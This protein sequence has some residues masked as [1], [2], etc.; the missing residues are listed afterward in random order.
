[1]TENVQLSTEEQMIAFFVSRC[2]GKIGR[3]Q[4][5]KLVYLADYE[6]RRYL[7]RPLS[8]FEYI[9][10]NHGPFDQ[11]I[12]A[13]IKRLK[14][15]ALV[16]EDQ[17][18]YP[19]GR[20]GFVYHSK[21]DGSAL[22]TLSPEESL[23]VSY[24]C[25]AYS[26]MEL[27]ALLTDVVYETEPM[28]DAREREARGEPLNMDMVNNSRHTLHGLAFEELFDR[29]MRVRAG[30]YVSHAAAMRMLGTKELDAAA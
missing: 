5:F 13:A 27:Q 28:L 10:Y 3:T 4:L 25:R 7:G 30:D 2:S 17:M 29:V 26:G 19:T 20:T 24:V 14:D 9:W 16:E 18:Q 6:A 12:Y 22:A 23:I 11:D 21:I 8:G 15:F 1:M